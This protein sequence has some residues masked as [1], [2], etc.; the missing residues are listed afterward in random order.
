[1]F[2]N[3]ELGV[4]DVKTGFKLPC[5]A[6]SGKMGSSTSP[7]FDQEMITSLRITGQLLLLE[8]YEMLQ[9]MGVDVIQLNTDG[10]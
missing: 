6:I 5:N 10:V 4:N 8:V 2:K 3:I 9:E 7:A 1:M